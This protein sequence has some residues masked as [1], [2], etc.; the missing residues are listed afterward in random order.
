M[1]STL[2]PP[3]ADDT[4]SSNVDDRPANRSTRNTPEPPTDSLDPAD[5]TLLPPSYLFFRQISSTSDGVR[6][7]VT[8][9]DQYTAGDDISVIET[10]SNYSCF[11]LY[12]FPVILRHITIRN[13]FTD[14]EASTN[15]TPAV[16]TPPWSG[17][18][19]YFFCDAGPQSYLQDAL[20]SVMWFDD[21][22]ETNNRGVS[23]LQ[24]STVGYWLPEPAT[25]DALL[26][27]D[28]A[29]SDNSNCCSTDFLVDEHSD[30]D[31]AE[32]DDNATTARGDS[33]DGDDDAG[34]RESPDERNESDNDNAAEATV[35]S[36]DPRSS[37]EAEQ[38][39]KN[40]G[41]E[42]DD[43]AGSTEQTADGERDA[44]KMAEA[45]DERNES[46]S[47][48][49]AEASESTPNPVNTIPPSSSKANHLDGNDVCPDEEADN[50]TGGSSD[51]A[52]IQTS[53]DRNH[54]EIDVASE[55]DTWNTDNISSQHMTHLHAFYDVRKIPVINFVSQMTPFWWPLYQTRWHPCMS[56]GNTMN[57]IN[58]TDCYC[59]ANRAGSLCM[60]QHI[61]RQSKRFP[62]I[63][64]FVL[65]DSLVS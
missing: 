45:L 14:T 1:P 64:R 3:Q 40:G 29:L 17:L 18:T 32:G 51:A 41:M 59:Y 38:C 60:L 58:L 54:S 4:A 11:D 16:A 24:R 9:H 27:V 22:F 65:V 36:L 5:Q 62:Q 12:H 57:V 56:P 61:S 37:N 2:C 20:H 21:T 30:D 15:Y 52:E 42:I 28:N 26:L 7:Y 43:D 13:I 31:D 34:G 6:A 46:G 50:A 10:E 25:L 39:S 55:E 49:A 19:R 53:L 48:N 63:P 8:G 44:V 23:W 35:R 33:D 47:N